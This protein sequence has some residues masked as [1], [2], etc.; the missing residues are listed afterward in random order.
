MNGI[1]LAFHPDQM[2]PLYRFNF[3][4]Y[5]AFFSAVSRAA[6]EAVSITTPP[7]S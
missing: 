4:A 5:F 1:K 2:L 6:A 3:P 7:L